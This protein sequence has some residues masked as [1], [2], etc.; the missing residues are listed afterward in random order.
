MGR[1]STITPAE[2]RRS[3][4]AGELRLR[5]LQRRDDPLVVVGRVGLLHRLPHDSSLKI[6]S[7][8]ITAETFRSDSPGRSRCGSRPVASQRWPPSR[9]AGAASAP[10]LTTVNGAVDLLAHEAMIKL[11]RAVRGVDLG[12]VLTDG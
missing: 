11:A 6:A 2:L 1:L 10:Q 3:R 9:A 8:S 7:P 12:D 4:R 5:Q